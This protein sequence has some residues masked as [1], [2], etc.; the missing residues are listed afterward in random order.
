V[1]ADLSDRSR[2]TKAHDPEKWFPV[3]GP[4][5]APLERM[6]LKNGFRFSDQIMR[7]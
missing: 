1:A 3:F 5:H 6:I 2:A 7:S 4:N